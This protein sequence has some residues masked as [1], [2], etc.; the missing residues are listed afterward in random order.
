MAL[1][2]I[3]GV[4]M[5]SPSAMTPG[6]A[7]LGKWERNARGSMIGELIAT[8]AKFELSWSFLTAVQLSK[9]LI[10]VKPLFFNVTYIDPVTNTLRTA[11]FYKGDRSMPVMDY[12]NGIPRYK[13]VKFNII[14][15]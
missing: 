13:D 8:K 9:L 6:E 3:N 5:P 14:E 10:A 11:T 12:R 2:K 4:D 1:L 7:D 15:K